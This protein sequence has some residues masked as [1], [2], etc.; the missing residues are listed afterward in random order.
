[1]TPAQ[2]LIVEDKAIVAKDIQNSLKRLGYHAPAIATSFEQALEKVAELRPDLV[3]MDIRLKGALDGVAAAAEIRSRFD[4]PVIYLTAHADEETLRRA[5]LTEPFG[6]ILKPFEEKELHIAVQIGLYKHEV[7]RKLREQERWL[8]ATLD[9]IGDAVLT[10][11]VGGKLI[12]LNPAAQTLIGW[13]AAEARGKEVSEIL[14]FIDE[15]TGAPAV[16]PLTLALQTGSATGLAGPTFI[17]TREGVERPIEDIAT[18]IRDETDN[19]IGGVLVFRDVLKTRQLEEQL[20]QAQKMEAVGQLA[21][22]VAHNFNNMLTAIIGY[23]SLVRE[24]LPADHASNLDLQTVEQT[25]QR[26]A[27]MVRHLLAFSRRQVTQPRLLN[28]NVLIHSMETMLRQI[29]PATIEL[30]VRAEPNPGQVKIDSGQIEQV[31]V[32]L[33][34]NARDAMPNGGQLIIRTTNVL[35]EQTYLDRYAEIPPGQYIL[36]TVTDTG[37]G[38][39]EE[40]MAHIF[41]PFFTTKE[42]GQGTGLGLST[43]FGIVQQNNGYISVK[44][45]P[46]RGS[47]FKIYLPRFEETLARPAMEREAGHPP[48]GSETV[49]LVEDEAQVRALAARILRQYG[50]TVLEASN[51]EDALHLIRMQPE[52]AIH[53][54]VTDVVMPKVSGKALT[55]LLRVIYPNLKVLFISGYTDIENVRQGTTF[56]SKPFTPSR[57]AHKVREILDAS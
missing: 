43:C 35:L 46:G 55:N 47:I 29:L 54:L 20:R 9:S 40:V 49:L 12:S 19:I 36:L 26:A 13:S 38:M 22:G 42:V 10:T 8:A 52:Q 44:S 57:L 23:V 31:L 56:L 24:S 4:I 2:I 16:N 34:L 17:V 7:E 51:G 21:A 18:P 50:Y 45:E 27:D 28:L 39:T 11:D 15:K 30:V 32:N 3:L 5:R 14:R 41:E 37:I 48:R 1:M 6:Y 53:L 25:A 33:A